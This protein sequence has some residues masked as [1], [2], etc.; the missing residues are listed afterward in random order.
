MST[1]GIVTAL[2]TGGF[3]LQAPDA[4]G[5]DDTAT[6]EGIFI[7]S[8]DGA[9]RVGDLLRADGRVQEIPA[10]ARA[11]QPTLTQIAATRITVLGRGQA[12]PRVMPL[13]PA[14]FERMEAMRVSL[15]GLRVVGPAEGF[16]DTWAQAS[17]STGRF[18]VASSAQRA[19]PMLVDS[20]GQNG[21]AALSA[22]VGD[23]IRGLVGV[24]GQGGDGYKLLPDPAPVARVLSAAAPRRVPKAT[25]GVATIGSLNLRRLL[26]ERPIAGQPS[27]TANAHATRMAKT[28]NVICAYAGTPDILA[29]QGVENQAAL[30]ELA[31]SVNARDGNLL[32]PG[33]CSGDPGYRAYLPPGRMDSGLQPG[34]LVSTASVRPGV[35]RVEVLSVTRG[36]PAQDSGPSNAPLVMEARINDAQ[37]HGLRLT[38]IDAQFSALPRDASSPGSQ[39]GLE[40]GRAA[41]SAW[42][43]EVI[44]ARQRRNP[45][46][47]LLVLGDFD[48]PGDGDASAATAT[49]TNLTARLPLAERYTVVSDGER[50]AADLMF[51]NAA[52]LKSSPRAHVNVARVNADFGEDNLGDAGVPMRVSDHDPIVGYFELR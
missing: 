35:P 18:Y 3:F 51:A 31:V 15:H 39:H 38:V 26:E 10:G 27:P 40:K 1:S 32:F 50:Q 20:A 42:L 43:A 9:V 25:S 52:L 28:A 23:G 14:G 17:L 29:V 37:G 11:D 8:A 33:S 5:D 21:A 19:G 4:Q 24:L 30:S 7:A 34:F 13:E 45:E 22:D 48:A 16:L 44:A 49:L 12:L 6:S 2:T 46:G 36:E 47:K 41:Q